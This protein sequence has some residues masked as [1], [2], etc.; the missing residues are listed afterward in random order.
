MG[1]GMFCRRLNSW[2]LVAV[3]AL[4][5]ISCGGSTNVAGISGTGVDNGSGTNVAGISGT[6]ITQGT[7]T[8]FGSIFV[9]GVKFEVDDDTVFDVD[10][11]PINVATHQDDLKV[12][13]VVRLDWTSFDDGTVSADSVTY[14]DSIEGPITSVVTDISASRKSFAVM[15]VTIEV[16][17]GETSFHNSSTAASFGFDNIAQN[18]VIEV[19]GFVGTNNTVTAT[20]VE[21]KGVLASP[22]SQVAVEMHGVVANL[23]PNTSFEL[24][25]VLV[26]FS[27]A[28]RLDNLPGGIQ[29][30]SSVEVKGLYNAGTNS[31]QATEIEGEDDNGIGSGINPD[32][33]VSIQGLISSFV[34]SAEFAING[35]PVQVN[36][37]L[38]PALVLGQLADGLLVEVE[39]VFSNNVLVADQVELREAQAEYRAIVFSRD[40]G[41]Q[42][43]SIQYL[44]VIGVLNMQIDSRSVIVDEEDRPISLADINVGDDV[45]IDARVLD[46]GDHLVVRI[47]RERNQNKSYEITGEVQ[48]VSLNVSITIEELEFPLETIV[49][50]SGIG[51]LGNVTPG[52][53]VSLEDNDRNGLINEVDSPD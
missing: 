8:G 48:A 38:V 22:S 30:G 20:L 23:T 15:G 3:T 1:L 7:I 45:K 32:Q 27:A 46:N 51:G 42:S 11:V 14:D 19:S 47:K 53:R 34:S 35:I 25:G 17:A 18:D 9:N 4:L 37:S 12:G 24:N 16:D 6:G 41:T 40:D 13:M 26:N 31:I 21:K 50:Y 44:Q 52:T 36:T 29:S 10:G 49:D 2:L 43:L 5:V 28:T 33:S 39:G